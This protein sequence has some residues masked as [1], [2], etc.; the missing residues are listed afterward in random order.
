[1]IQLRDYQSGAVAKVRNHFINKAKS[2]IISSEGGT[3]KTVI[4][5]YM[6][7]HAQGKGHRVVIL[8][9]R[10]ELAFQAANKMRGYG[11][12]PYVFMQSAL[13]DS[14]HR[15]VVASMQTCRSRGYPDADLVIVDECH[16]GDFIPALEYYKTTTARIIGVSATPEK[17]KQNRISDFYE[18]MVSTKLTIDHIIDGELCDCYAVYGEEKIDTT[19]IKL[20]KKSYGQDYDDKALFAAFDK[21]KMYAGLVNLYQKEAGGLSAMCFNINVEHSQKTA[22]AFNAA[23]I[24]AIHLDAKIPDAERKSIFAKFEAGYYKVLCVVGIGTYGYDFPDLR[25]VIMNRN[26]YSQ[27]LYRQMM[28]RGSRPSTGKNFFILI[29]MGNNFLRFGGMADRPDYELLFKEPE[30]KKKKKS[31]AEGVTPSKICL[32]CKALNSSMA[33]TCVRCNYPFPIK[34]VEDNLKEA[35]FKRSFG[36]KDLHVPPDFIKWPPAKQQEFMQQIAAAKAQIL[37]KDGT[38]MSAMGIVRAMVMG[39]DAKQQVTILHEYA[40]VK[41]HKAGWVR[42]VL[43]VL[44]K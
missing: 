9:N 20:V 12:K 36:V 18:E 10:Q 7:F 41:G 38:P 25:C 35:E 16:L 19:G 2:V 40:K 14:G 34:K 13:P 21:P 28:T 6:S 29:D 5:C 23:G 32:N 26:T 31:D 15:V 30:S 24:P 33:R 42:N 22:M 1:M 43:K 27:T 11:I 8:V 44:A 39:H 4:F 37:R 17:N 3:G